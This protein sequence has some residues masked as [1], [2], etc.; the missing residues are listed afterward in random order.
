MFYRKF[1]LCITKASVKAHT[2]KVARILRLSLWER[3][4]LVPLYHKSAEKTS[5]LPKFMCHGPSRTPVPTNCNLPYENKPK[6]VAFHIIKAS[7]RR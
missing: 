1:R 5:S 2:H 4:F 7:P 3:L 6:R